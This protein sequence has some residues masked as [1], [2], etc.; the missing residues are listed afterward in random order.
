MSPPTLPFVPPPEA[1][2]FEL[3]SEHT[4]PTR[5][6]LKMFDARLMKADSIKRK[7][8]RDLDN[9]SSSSEIKHPGDVYSPL[10]GIENTPPLPLVE[11]QRPQKLEVEVPLPPRSPTDPPSR[12][13]KVASFPESL[14][15][16]N[17]DLPT[18]LEKPEGEVSSDN[19]NSFAKP[20]VPVAAAKRSAEQ[21][22]LEKADPMSKVKVPPMDFTRPVAPWDLA[23]SAPKGSTKDTRTRD[24][25]KDTMEKYFE[26]ETWHYSAKEERSLRWAPFPAH[27]ARARV[28]ET[29][30]IEEDELNTWI[31]QPPCM[32]VNT[33]IGKTGGLRLNQADGSDEEKIE[34]GDYPPSND[35]AVPLKRKAIEMGD[36]DHAALSKTSHGHKPIHAKKP[37][38]D[39]VATKE[40]A[41]TKELG[42][43]SHDRYIELDNSRPTTRGTLDTTAKHAKSDTLG[44]SF[45]T[46]TSIGNYMSLRTGQPKARVVSESSFFKP[47]KP[48]PSD[49]SSSQRPTPRHQEL[50]EY[51]APQA[52][53]HA[54]PFPT[55]AIQLP[56]EPR[57]FMASASSLINKKVWRRI[58][59]LYPDA[60]II[61]RDFSHLPTES[62]SNSNPIFNDEKLLAY[63]V[64]I[65][66]SP[67]AGL[68]WTT[69]QKIKQ[70]SLP[71]QVASSPIRERIV[72]TA[73]RYEHLIIIISQGCSPNEPLPY[74]DSDA[75]ALATLTSFCACLPSNPELVFVPGYDLE[76]AQ[77]TVHLMIKHSTGVPNFELQEEETLWEVWLRRAGM[78]AFAAQYVLSQMQAPVLSREDMMLDKYR[79]EFGLAAFVAM[80]AREREETFAEVVGREVLRRVERNVRGRWGKQAG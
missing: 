80:G 34:P 33:L 4:S 38:I 48:V 78:N 47:K 10:K 13:E 72:H 7:R 54:V 24:F 37:R 71:G 64:D 65:A 18:V 30:D 56:L 40:C 5:E 20:I 39:P 43:H 27:L 8:D 75:T 70:K 6:I 68:I 28:Q 16:I 52:S 50:A 67:S 60:C 25:L 59:A 23:S 32:D 11:R 74:T 66:L 35:F 58:Y 19:N 55:P 36:K 22:Q 1:C 42:T 15:E 21:E 3:L 57:H 31:A 62:A 41:S 46:F 63:E 73:N 45:S 2:Q 69:L 49:G 79:G 14:L 17:P 29:I 51:R 76:L 44:Q 53:S 77:W 12:E 9:A 26:G 61:E